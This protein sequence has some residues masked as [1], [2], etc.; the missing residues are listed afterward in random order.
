[1]QDHVKNCETYGIKAAYLGSAQLDLQLEEHVLSGD[2]D[3][4][5]V[6][7]TPE[8]IAKADKKAK[9]QRL[10]DENSLLTCT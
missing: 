5:I 10:I 7:V 6:L 4:S 8:W 3:V 2:S 1:M 9:I